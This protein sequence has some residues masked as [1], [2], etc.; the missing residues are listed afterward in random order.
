[1]D[2]QLVV[3][4]ASATAAVLSAAVS[5]YFSR[6]S[7][8][9]TREFAQDQYEDNI[10]AWAERTVEITSELRQLASNGSRTPNPDLIAKLLADLS[11]QIEKGRWFFPNVL[12]DKA[13]TWKEP[14]YQGIRQR[15][16]DD[17]VDI[18]TAVEESDWQDRHALH[19]KVR[20]AHRSFVSRVQVKLDPSERDAAYQEMLQQYQVQSTFVAQALAKADS[21]EPRPAGGPGSA[22]RM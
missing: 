16:L 22:P 9:Q 2:G 5:F 13:G 4:V 7:V 3:S 6:Q 19:Q 21:A 1:M 12:T 10:R 18:H 11:A 14:A 15:V 20:A 8:E 17:L